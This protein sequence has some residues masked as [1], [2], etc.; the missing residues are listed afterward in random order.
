MNYCP[1]IWWLFH[2]TWNLDPY[3]TTSWW[4][5]QTCFI[6][7]PYLGKISKLTCA[8]FFRWVV[9]NHQPGLVLFCSTLKKQKSLKISKLMVGFGWMI[10]PRDPI[11]SPKVRWWGFRGV[12]HHRNETLLTFRFHETILRFSEPGSL[13]FVES[14]ENGFIFRHINFGGGGRISNF[15]SSRQKLETC[16]IHLK[17]Q[18]TVGNY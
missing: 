18:E 17:C 5:F 11:S 14:V 6:F 8:Y 12:L 9:K 13:G 16:Q 3:W 4:W 2:K 7:T 15:S 10:D 1:V